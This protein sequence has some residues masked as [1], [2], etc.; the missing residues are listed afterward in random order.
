[1]MRSFLILSSLLLLA[2]CEPATSPKAVDPNKL[3][4]IS[5]QEQALITAAQAAEQN[6]DLN[7]A[8]RDYRQAMKLSKGHV[9]AHLALAELYLKHKQYGKAKAVLEEGIEYQPNHVA[10]NYMLG[11]IHLRD[12]E[13]STALTAFERGLKTRPSHLDLLSGAGVANDMLRK[14]SAAQVLYLR[15]IALNPTSDLEAV[16]TNLAMSYLLDNQPA[17]AAETL[18]VDAAKEGASPVTRHNLALAYGMLGRHAEAKALVHGEMTEE[19]RQAALKRLSQ[20]IAQRDS[21]TGKITPYE[22]I[23]PALVKEKQ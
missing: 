8:E 15:A 7:R 3:E 20:Y 13:P 21:K 14:H 1:M 23:S 17:K 5:G 6:S 2:A 9:E 19:E 16:R 4:P 11:K 22:A 10:L 18:K 12:D